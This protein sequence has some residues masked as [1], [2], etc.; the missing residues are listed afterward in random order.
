MGFIFSPKSCFFFFFKYYC[1]LFFHSVRVS[2][3]EEDNDI[4]DKIRTF[5]LFI[6]YVGKK[7]QEKT[8]CSSLIFMCVWY[9]AGY[10]PLVGWDRSLPGILGDQDYPAFN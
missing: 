9:Q 6:C 7:E 4:M 10:W 3:K 2:F 1:W 5:Y 8:A